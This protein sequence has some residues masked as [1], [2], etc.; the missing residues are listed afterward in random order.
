MSLWTWLKSLSTRGKK[1]EQ[2]SVLET[3]PEIAPQPL[4]ASSPLALMAKSG[5]ICNIADWKTITKDIVFYLI[6]PPGFKRNAD[7]LKIYISIDKSG[8]YLDK[9]IKEQRATINVQDEAGNPVG[10]IICNTEIFRLLVMGNLKFNTVVSG[11]EPVAA[12]NVDSPKGEFKLEV[13]EN[14][15]F[16][17]LSM[18]FFDNQVGYMC[19]ECIA[20]GQEVEME[21]R[22]KVS[23]PVVTLADGTKVE[24]TLEGAGDEIVVIMSETPPSFNELFDGTTERAIELPS[25]VTVNV[26]IEIFS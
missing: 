12:L 4:P 17:H 8:L 15:A 7:P 24:G 22:L 19:K 9:K 25:Q 26:A 11:F 14:T 1:A 3:L 18:M 21:I 16:N 23:N 13:T 10:E 2:V 6:I 20:N 5:P